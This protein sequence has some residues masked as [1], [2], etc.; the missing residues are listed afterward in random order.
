MQPQPAATRSSPLPVRVV[1]V[2]SSVLYMHSLPQRPPIICISKKFDSPA[3]KTR[4]I[5]DSKYTTQKSK[6][7]TIMDTQ[8]DDSFFMRS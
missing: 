4:H 2:T 7:Y 6:Y 3:S 5:A 8:T 1:T